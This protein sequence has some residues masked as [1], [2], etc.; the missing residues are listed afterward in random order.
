[1][2]SGTIYWTL[3]RSLLKQTRF[4]SLVAHQAAAV[5]QQTAMEQQVVQLLSQVRQLEAE[6]AAMESEHQQEIN[7]LK[8]KV[9]YGFLWVFQYPVKCHYYVFTCIMLFMLLLLS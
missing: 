9:G 1:M 4:N 2:I 7:K 3:Q 5:D 6:K 8:E